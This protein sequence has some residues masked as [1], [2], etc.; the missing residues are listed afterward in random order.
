M[1]NGIR[2][3]VDKATNNAHYQSDQVRDG[4]LKYLSCHL[5]WK[6]AQKTI[7]FFAGKIPIDENSLVAGF[8]K[9]RK[10]NENVSDT[11]S[12]KQC[13]LNLA[14]NEEH[15][16][17]SARLSKEVLNYSFHSLDFFQFI[18]NHLYSDK[19]GDKENIN[20][21]E[22]KLTAKHQ[23]NSSVILWLLDKSFDSFPDTVRVSDFLLDERREIDTSYLMEPENINVV[24]KFIK[25]S[26]SWQ[27]FRT[28]RKLLYHDNLC[29]GEQLLRI[30]LRL[31]IQ[32]EDSKSSDSIT[33]ADVEK[34]F[35]LPPMSKRNN[36]NDQV[37][38]S[39]QSDY[40]IHP[41]FQNWKSRGC[42]NYCGNCRYCQARL[43]CFDEYECI[44]FRRMFE[45]VKKR[46][47][48]IRQI[49]L[50]HLCSPL[51]EIIV[52]F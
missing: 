45:D 34:L 14:Q 32:R 51:V 17:I 27:E 40:Y 10:T 20:Q 33:V 49:L 43:D 21:K 37:N 38:S 18:L 5:G 28:L 3:L 26:T 9:D 1:K 6:N 42:V 12:F 19:S 29:D 48:T 25:D 23:K 35:Q 47:A 39:R 16:K 15:K 2:D 36:S 4:M 44:D 7:N 22:L 52:N 24:T 46:V 11:N 13:F 31:R 50:S 41:V 30:F 8:I